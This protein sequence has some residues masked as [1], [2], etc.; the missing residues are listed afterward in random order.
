[1][2]TKEAAEKEIG[3]TEAGWTD[4]EKLSGLIPLLPVKVRS[5]DMFKSR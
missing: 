3:K 5:C 2:I 4:S 1:M